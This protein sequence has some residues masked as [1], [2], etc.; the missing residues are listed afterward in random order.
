MHA[1]IA[2]FS[3]RCGVYIANLVPI[4]M[5]N[6]AMGRELTDVR[7]DDKPNGTVKSNGSRRVWQGIKSNNY[8]VKSCT[9]E[10]SV[11]ENGHGKQD[12][13]AVKSTKFGTN[14]PEGKNEKV[15]DQKSADNK[16]LSNAASKMGANGT[17]KFNSTTSPTA[18]KGLEPNNPTTPMMSRKH[19]D[20]EDNWSVASTYPL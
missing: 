14:T 20:E 8:E 19:P 4:Y 2:C 10:K 5:K 9:V 17:E 15:E 13:L 18:G 12:V 7:M 6:S 1:R 16:K 11:L 3:R